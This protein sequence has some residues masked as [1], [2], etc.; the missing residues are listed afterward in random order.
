MARD[1]E[2]LYHELLEYAFDQGAQDR[3]DRAVALIN[4]SLALTASTLINTVDPA[5]AYSE[6]ANQLGE[7]INTGIDFYNADEPV[8][9][10]P[11]PRCRKRREAKKTTH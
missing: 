10:C 9:E 7:K 4:F 11:C 3:Q 1:L 2:A 8:E 5:R 6:F